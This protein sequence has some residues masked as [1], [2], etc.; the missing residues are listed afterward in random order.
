MPAGFLSAS[1]WHRPAEQPWL[2]KYLTGAHRTER[3]A[4]LRSVT[5][6]WSDAGVSSHTMSD[7][8]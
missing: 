1:N 8:D 4:W 2:F 5:G 7:S 3:M 6:A